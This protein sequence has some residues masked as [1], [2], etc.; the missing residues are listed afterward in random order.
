VYRWS[1]ITNILITSMF[2]AFELGPFLIWT[3]LLFIL[4]GIWLAPGRSAPAESAR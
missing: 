4:L 2:Q 1:P 3:R